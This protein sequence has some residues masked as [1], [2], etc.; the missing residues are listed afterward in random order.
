MGTV[1]SLCFDPSWP[2]DSKSQM[3][4][5]R[6]TSVELVVLDVTSRL[7]S[8]SAHEGFERYALV[9]PKMAFLYQYRLEFVRQFWG[10]IMEFRLGKS[11]LH[12]RPSL[13]ATSL[14]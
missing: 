8:K 11:S 5:T 10:A 9:S 7:H 6:V 2:S 3:S 14:N 12:T 1:C 13:F 4:V